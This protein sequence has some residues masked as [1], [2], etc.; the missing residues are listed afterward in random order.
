M[1]VRLRLQRFGSKKRPFYRIVAASS[2]NKR[3]GKF[4][5]IIGLYHPISPEEN[6][7]RLNEDRIRH[8]LNMGAQPSET[9]KNVLQKQGIWKEFMA[10]K[11]KRKAE[12]RKRKNQARK[13]QKTQAAAATE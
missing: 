10:E 8:W 2:A 13:S 6:Q 1:T 9:V 11:T 12:K 5:E 4:L 7:I 3:D